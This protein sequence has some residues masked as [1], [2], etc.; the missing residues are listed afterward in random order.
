VLYVSGQLWLIAAQAGHG[1]GGVVAATNQV[2]TAALAQV[3]ESTSH[4][5][6]SLRLRRAAAVRNTARLN[7]V[8]APWVMYESAQRRVQ[9]AKRC[10]INHINLD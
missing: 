8:S 1:V 2:T 4:E 7:F 9:R 6:A 3:M 5:A 10:Q